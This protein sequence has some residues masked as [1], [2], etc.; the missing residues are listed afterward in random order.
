MGF[1][2]FF[3]SESKHSKHHHDNDRY[4]RSSG[5]HANHEYKPQH[6]QRASSIALAILNNPKYRFFV[7]VAVL[8]VLAIVVAL[9]VA[10][11]PYLVRLLDFIAD[12]GVVGV[13]DT[14]L[15]GKK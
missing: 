4:Y 14:V 7:I 11:F 10:L 12:K 6:S 1:D 8:V 9:V 5:Y 2:D 15:N 3:D 13:F